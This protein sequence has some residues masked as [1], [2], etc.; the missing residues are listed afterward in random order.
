MEATREIFGEKLGELV[1]NVGACR[2]LKAPTKFL[3]SRRGAKCFLPFYAARSPKL[4]AEATPPSSPTSPSTIRYGAH[5][6]VLSLS[7]YLSLVPNVVK[8]NFNHILRD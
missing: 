3:A 8:R 6:P 5:L 4:F 2:E 1:A 7:L